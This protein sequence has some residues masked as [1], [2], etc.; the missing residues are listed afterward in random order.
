MILAIEVVTGIIQE[1]IKRYGRNNNNNRR[2]SY[3]N[4][5]TIGIGHMKDIIETEETIET[6]VIVDRDQVQE[7]V[8][9][10]IGL[11]VLNVGN[12]IILQGE[13]PN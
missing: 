10:E 6:Q 11:D 7:Q 4:Q 2:G 1:V 3:K 9:I 8:Q 12:M 5:I 13:C